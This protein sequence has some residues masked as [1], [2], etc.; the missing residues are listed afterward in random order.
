MTLR[1]VKGMNDILP[2]EIGRWHR[3]EAAFRQAVELH[4]YRE[5]RTPL[6]EPTSLFVRS[7]GETTDVVE[8]EMFSFA[9]H[10]DEITLRPEGTAGAARAYVEHQ[11]FA[12]QPVTRWFYIGPMYRGETPAKGRYRQFHQAGCEVY[13][14]PGPLVD[15]EMIDMLVGF[16]KSIGAPDFEVVLNSLGSPETRNRY[17]Q[18]L[19]DYF[20]P[21]KDQLSA[22]SQRRLATNPLRILDS[23]DEKDQ[24]LAAQGPQILDLLDGDDRQHFDMLR[25]HLD[26]MKTPYRV[27]PRLV[28]GLDYYNRTLF[29][30]RITSDVLGAQG[31]LGGG[32]RYDR[33][34]GELGGRETPC[35]GFGLGLERILLV[36]SLAEAQRQAFVYVAPMGERAQSEALTV[37]KELRAAGIEVQVDGR[38]Q[39]F[40]TMLHRANDSGARYC[41]VIGDNEVDKGVLG[42]KDLAAHSQTDIARVDVVSYLTTQ[43]RDASGGTR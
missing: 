42:I 28:R 19:L 10:R 22:D 14:D 15:A 29:E 21:L 36:S 37:A 24:A 34:V 38:G 33:M 39:K 26:A 16:L 9:H 17:R 12:K 18:A 30:L 40:K 4:G 5:I 6:V 8:K 11:I 7:I 25:R 31:T 13:G 3:V 43:I 1:A 35:I 32:G 2:D 20:T 27:D 23:K 41:I